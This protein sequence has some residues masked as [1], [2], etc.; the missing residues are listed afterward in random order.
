MK[1]IFLA[2]MIATFMVTACARNPDKPV[3]SDDPSTPQTGSYLPDPGDANLMRDVVYLDS[4]D[5]LTMESFPLQFS[6]VLKGNL[7]TPCH[8]LRIAANEPDAENKIVVDVYSV[9]DPNTT[10]IMVLE[11]FEANLPLGSYPAG[12]YSLWVNG[13]QV[14]EFDA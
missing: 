12:H 9:I 6:L 1:R 11:P 7:P 14:A 4:T 8:N 13:R 3:S 10:C 2:L 5:L